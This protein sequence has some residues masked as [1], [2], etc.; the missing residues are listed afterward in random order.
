V[1]NG[2]RIAIVMPA[3]NAAKTL[4]QTV[5]YYVPAGTDTP[6]NAYSLS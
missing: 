3:Y 1:V 6:K 2:K 5:R 4:A